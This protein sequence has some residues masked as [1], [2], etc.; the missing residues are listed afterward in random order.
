V[1]ND[2]AAAYISRARGAGREDDWP[3]ALEASEQAIHLDPLLI[4]ARF[5]RA[6]ALESMSLW[7]EAEKAWLDYLTVAGAARDGWAE[8]ANRHLDA[9]RKR[10]S[11]D[12]ERR[13]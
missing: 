11:S 8:E 12:L 13:N 1:R 4:E 9:L 2:L 7:A 5:N 10:P 6:Y 3:R